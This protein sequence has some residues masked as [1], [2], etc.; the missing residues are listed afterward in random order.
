[1]GLITRGI[2]KGKWKCKDGCIVSRKEEECMMVN[3]E[4]ASE[5]VTTNQHEVGE[6]S[7]IRVGL[8]LQAKVFKRSALAR[9]R[10]GN[11]K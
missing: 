7:S 10:K 8:S 3:V 4:E 5:L 2:N 6:D 9:M 1:M 11:A